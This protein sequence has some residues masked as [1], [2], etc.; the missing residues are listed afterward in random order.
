MERLE[1]AAAATEE[2][3][4]DADVAIVTLA[5][6]QLSSASDC[7]GQPLKHGTNEARATSRRS[8]WLRVTGTLSHLRG[9]VGVTKSTASA[10][11][12]EP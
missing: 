7:C 11:S 6:S 8:V 4:L 3:V 2:L 5:G 1:L 10:S 12:I 9:P